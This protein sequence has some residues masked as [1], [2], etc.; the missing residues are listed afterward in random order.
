MATK[1]YSTFELDTNVPGWEDLKVGEQIKVCHQTCSAGV[2]SRYRMYVKRI[3]DATTVWYC[4]NCSEHGYVVD[5]KAK[6]SRLT[7]PR[8]DLLHEVSALFP[9]PDWPRIFA[10]GDEPPIEAK[11][12][13]EQY[14]MSGV[15]HY[16]SEYTRR[17]YLPIMHQ[18]TIVGSQGRLMIGSIPG[19]PKYLTTINTDTLKIHYRFVAENKPVWVVEDL[20]SAYKLNEVGCNSIALLGT[21]FPEKAYHFVADK[22]VL[23]WLDA[24]EAG[25]KGA[26]NI[27][28]TLAPISEVIVINSETE[29][30]E[31][32]LDTLKKLA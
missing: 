11:M 15:Q 4:H 25:V 13:L 30:K 32:P 3:T 2:D 19:V 12:W 23:L 28:K 6:F 26:M 14:E 24:D 1:N 5:R 20:L 27:K 8:V 31:T 10:E 7:D 16:Y 22:T 18:D 17:L 29:A 9:L 21:H